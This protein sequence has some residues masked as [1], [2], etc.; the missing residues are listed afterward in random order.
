MNE[1]IR[2]S[3]SCN[4]SYFSTL[5]DTYQ[6]F[7]INYRDTTTQTVT[8]NSQYESYGTND[9]PFNLNNS[10]L[11]DLSTTL[12][13]YTILLTSAEI[14]DD[15]KSIYGFEIYGL[16]EG[17]VRITILNPT[18][19]RANS[20]SWSDY[21]QTAS[22]LQ[23]QNITELYL[24]IQVGYNLIVLDNQ[25]DVRRGTLFSYSPEPGSGRIALN[26]NS[27]STVDYFYTNGL[28]VSSLNSTAQ[29]WRFYF[30]VLT[31]CINQTT[32][33]PLIKTYT[34]Q[35][36]YQVNITYQ[37]PIKYYDREPQNIGLY[38]RYSNFFY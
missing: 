33:S 8:F 21:F 13:P 36:T 28:T 12:D 32:S 20:I 11:F 1:H 16:Q 17:I 9:I 10:L 2:Q 23:S 18:T 25:I 26:R 31:Q 4:I 35:G 5:Y 14:L 37:N 19:S 24:Y 15:F 3:F 30:K 34:T 27:S 29:K 6:T 38:L 22:T 7:L